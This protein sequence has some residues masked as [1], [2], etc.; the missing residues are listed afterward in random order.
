[1]IHN[2]GDY[3]KFSSGWSNSYRNIRLY[4]CNIFTL[5][6]SERL[7][8]SNKEGANSEILYRPEIS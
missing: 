7:N 3:Y 6:Y 8:H 4:A 5:G 2:W 1:M